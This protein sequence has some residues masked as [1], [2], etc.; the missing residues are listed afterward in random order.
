[1]ASFQ[2]RIKRA[3]FQVVLWQAAGEPSPP[4]LDPVEYVMNITAPAASVIWELATSTS[5]P[6]TQV[7]RAQDRNIVSVHQYQVT[8]WTLVALQVA[9]CTFGLV[10]NVINVA[11]FI[12]MGVA[13][14]ATSISFF[15]LAVSDLAFVVAY[16]IFILLTIHGHF[17]SNFAYNVIAVFV[18]T[19][20]Y[21]LSSAITA[22]LSLQK[23]FC[24]AIPLKFRN[25]FTLQRTVIVLVFMS[26]VITACFVPMFAT[27]YPVEFQN[28]VTN[29]SMVILAYRPGGPKLRRA[30]E[31]SIQYL[32][33][34]SAQVIVIVCLVILMTK[35]K[36]ASRFR[37]SNL[38]KTT[39]SDSANSGSF[40]LSGKEL[41][42]VK[43]VT[44]VAGMFV[45][46]NLPPVCVTMATIIEPRY[47]DTSL[48][49]R[50]YNA[51]T[52]ARYTLM[53]FCS[54]LNLLVYV[55]FNTNFRQT[56]ANMFSS[57]A[58]T[59]AWE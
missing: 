24:V 26:A 42:A 27:M 5:D 55:K 50:L 17:S 20:P 41:Q 18:F 33:P 13:E 22:Y 53:T 52:F 48:Y 46:C 43:A 28:S 7:T 19:L 2:A 39:E 56:L 29:S 47:H 1:M 30:F 44:V 4:E 25:V 51:I 36:Q 32:L 54:S 57:R 45:T 37:H 9:V 12:K 15:S 14:S 34:L 6:A 8:K 23:M 3:H 58:D 11:V 40:R 49:F 21:S 59:N 31:I 35:L 16:F 10:T 38:T